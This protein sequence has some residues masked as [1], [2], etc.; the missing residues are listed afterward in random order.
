MHYTIEMILNEDVSILEY[1]RNAKERW[2]KILEEHW[3]RTNA[4]E[5]SKLLTI[6][7]FWF[8]QNCGGRW[9]GQEIM[10]IVGIVQFYSTEKGF[11]GNKEKAL[12]VFDAFMKSYCSI[13]VK[14][15]AQDVAKDYYLI[16]EQSYG[17]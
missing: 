6:E 12:W 4:L 10:V 5:L 9:I 8:E 14:G 13:E 16:E 15:K 17:F 11:E 7:Q 1:Y 3:G 2:G